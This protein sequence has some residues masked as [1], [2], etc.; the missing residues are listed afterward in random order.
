MHSRFESVTDRFL[1][2]LKPIRETKVKEDD[3]RYETLLKGLKRVHIKVWPPEAFEEATDF[4]SEFSQCFSDAHGLKLKTAFAESLTH[5]L[6]PLS[7]VH[8]I[9]KGGYSG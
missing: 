4:M 7:K 9:D 8:I 5:L 3:G 1:R 6:H 2:E